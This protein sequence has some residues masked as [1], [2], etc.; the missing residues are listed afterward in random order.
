VTTLL[1]R[2]FKKETSFSL[3]APDMMMTKP[4]NM[5]HCHQEKTDRGVE[6]RG[7]QRGWE[8]RRKCK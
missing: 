8:R 6:G 4:P 1:L 3:S 2:I 5:A 7:R